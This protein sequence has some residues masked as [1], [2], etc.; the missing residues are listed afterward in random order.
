MQT[1]RGPRGRRPRDALPARAFI[2]SSILALVYVTAPCPA[3]VREAPARPGPASRSSRRALNSN[4]TNT[5]IPPRETQ[6]CTPLPGSPPLSSG[7]P[8]SGWQGW[9]F[10]M[11]PR[12]P[13]ERGSVD[14]HSKWFSVKEPSGCGDTDR[15]QVI[16]ASHYWGCDCGWE[17]PRAGDPLRGPGGKV[18]STE[19]S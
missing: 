15:L 19:V 11:L 18:D 6:G 2:G 16:T 12:G 4:H 1:P 3:G 8:A 5:V 7:L 13:A 17:Q 14:G 10:R 9:P